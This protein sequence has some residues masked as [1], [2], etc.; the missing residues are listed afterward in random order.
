MYIAASN[1]M[2]APSGSKHTQLHTFYTNAHIPVMMFYDAKP[3]SVITPVA[4]KPSEIYHQITHA[5]VH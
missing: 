1:T 3:Q 2:R 4:A 5:N